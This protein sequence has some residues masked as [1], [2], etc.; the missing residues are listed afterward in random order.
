MHGFIGASLTLYL[1]KIEVGETVMG[2]GS[3]GDKTEDYG[4]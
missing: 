4:T 1:V 2:E 3:I